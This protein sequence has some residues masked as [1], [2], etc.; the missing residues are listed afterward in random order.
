MAC[1]CVLMRVHRCSC[2]LAGRQVMQSRRTQLLPCRLPVCAML[3][4]QL[5][6]DPQRMDAAAVGAV[7]RLQPAGSAPPRPFQGGGGG[8]GCPGWNS[9]NWFVNILKCGSAADSPAVI[10]YFRRI[11]R[12]CWSE[13]YCTYR[14]HSATVSC[15]CCCRKA[16]HS[17]N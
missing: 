7:A 16:Q 11:C 6:A 17:P 3:W 14:N 8:G 13:D 15:C 4:Q 2:T 10:P 9:G 1:M 5:L 12:R